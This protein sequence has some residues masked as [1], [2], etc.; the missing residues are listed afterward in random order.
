MREIQSLTLD[1]A[2]TSHDVDALLIN[3]RSEFEILLGQLVRTQKLE[4]EA[5]WLDD[6]FRSSGTA[7]RCTGVPLMPISVEHIT[8][9]PDLRIGV[10]PVRVRSKIP[11][12]GEPPESGIRS[13]D[14]ID[15]REFQPALRG[16]SH[17]FQSQYTPMHNSMFVRSDGLIERVFCDL[18]P[19]TIR[20]NGRPNGVSFVSL[21]AFVLSVVTSIEVFR[22]GTGTSEVPYELEFDLIAHHAQALIAPDGHMR[23]ESYQFKS[24]RTLFPRFLMG[25]RE[26]LPAL[27]DALQTD[28]WNSAGEM[29]RV[30]YEYDVAHSIRLHESGH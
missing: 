4:N 23:A 20:S 12:P 21:V 16:W 3:R 28:I 9:R 22:T 18:T 14:N 17:I 5:V 8:E 19:A 25:R 26:S 24:R 1:R 2:R 27:S 6:N 10:Q 30:F 13:W 15:P 29:A 7:M 11:I